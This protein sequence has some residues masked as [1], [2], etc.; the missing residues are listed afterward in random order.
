MGMGHGMWEHKYAKHDMGLKYH[1]FINVDEEEVPWS[2][3][4]EW[5]EWKMPVRGLTEVS[6]KWM[7]RVGAAKKL[8][9]GAVT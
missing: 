7:E 6:W 8:C 5:K 3:L 4:T 9:T 1:T 2:K